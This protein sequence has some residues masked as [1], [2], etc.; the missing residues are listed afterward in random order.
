MLCQ[1]GAGSGPLIDL[2]ERPDGGEVIGPLRIG[3]VA[4]EQRLDVGAVAVIHRLQACDRLPSSDDGEALAA[5]FHGVEKVGEAPSRFGGCDLR[6]ED[7]I[8]RCLIRRARTVPSR[9]VTR[10]PT[11]GVQ[12]DPVGRRPSASALTGGRHASAERV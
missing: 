2:D 9:R 12:G 4:A 5:M 1:G 7:Q 10:A 6:H 8:I 3:P 11:A